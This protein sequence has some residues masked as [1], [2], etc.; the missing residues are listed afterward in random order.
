MKNESIEFNS[1]GNESA[2][3]VRKFFRV[4]VAENALVQISISEKKFLVS[5]ISQSG[6]G[7]ISDDPS[8]FKLGDLLTDCELKLM[9]TSIKGLTGKVIRAFSEE[10]GQLQFGILW[11]DLQISQ[12]KALDE[13]FLKMKSQILENNDRNIINAEK[14]EK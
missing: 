7:I 8:D 2:P 1:E 11:L 13:I 12:R 9:E 14:I 6:I 5:N 3:L 10:P 4:P